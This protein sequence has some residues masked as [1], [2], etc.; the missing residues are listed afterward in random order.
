MKV[1]KKSLKIAGIILL[2]LILL[3]FIIPVVFKK[4]VQALV[5][6]EINKQLNAKVDF[7]DAKLSLFKHF[8][9][10]TIS[11]KGLTIVGKDYYA[12]DTLIS[13]N[14]IDITAG[15]FSVLKG[16]DI[17][18]YGVYVKQPRIHLLVNQ[19]GR[20]NW[21][22]AKAPADTSGAKD[23]TAS[24][25]KLSLKK[26]KIS[27]GYLEYNDKKA[28]TYTELTG[29][30][31][32]GSGDITADIFTLSTS[33]NAVSAKF[34][35]DGIPYLVNAKTDLDADIKIDNKTN[36]YTFKTDDIQLNALRLSAEGFVQMLNAE[37]FKMDFKFSSPANDFKNILSMVPAIYTKDFAK[38]KTSGEASFS[39][40]VKGIYSPTQI[41]AYDVKLLVKNGSF[42]YPD[43][44]KPVK[45]VNLSL[46][47]HNPD[48]KPDNSVIDISKGHLEFDKEPFDFNFIYRNP[49]TIQYIDAGAK[50]R[51]DL[52][53]LSK[54]IKLDA[55]TQLRGQVWADAF[56]KGP[57]KAIE[58][59]SGPFRAGGFFDIRNLYYADKNFPQP[60]QN[61]NMKA[62]LTNAGGVADKT[63]IDIAQGHIEVG[64]DP[65]DFTLQL[66]NPVSTVNFSGKAKG[67]FTLDNLKQF[68]S[69]LAGTSLS[70][71]M[72]ADMGFAGSRAAINNSEYDKITL[73]GS[74]DFANVS[75]KSKDYPGGISIPA[76][77]LLF[78]AKN[79]TL[80]NLTGKYLGT[81]FTAAG[82]LNNLVG[83]MMENQPLTGNLTAS[84]D[85]MN[86][87]DWMGTPAE[88][89]SAPS[90]ASASSGPFLVP[91]GVNFTINS[92]VNKVKY[93]KVDYD[94]ITGTVLMNDEKVQFQN[95]KAD[96]LD[97]SIL[98]NGSYSTK[99]NKEKPDISLSY[100]VKNMSVQKAFYA[101]NTIKFLMPIG[102]YLSGKLHSQLSM[103]G[104]LDGQMMPLLNSLTGKGN[105]F[106]LE[107]VLEKFAPL[108]KI[109]AVLD[110]D[111]LKS[112]SVKDI[113][114]YIEFANGKV[115]VKPF[116]V[117]VKDIEMEIAGFHGLDQ[118]LDYGIKMKM[119]RAVIGTK[120]NKLVDSLVAKAKAKGIPISPGETISLHL[121]LTGTVS[122]PSVS[123][124]LEKMAG[125]AVKQVEDLAKD[126]VKAKL[127]S[128]TKKTRDSLEAV[129]KQVEDK[130]K[131]KL[132]NAGIDTTN[133]TIKNVKDTLKERVK[134][135]LKKKI[136]KKLLGN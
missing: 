41:P 61:G 30:N 52:S 18:V 107:G 38:M 92:T 53:Q 91:P 130:A 103:I 76:S 55:G 8:P 90:A 122:N 118:S 2:S 97:G 121:K 102:K 120:G 106:L 109:A 33:T 128:A 39:G 13:A 74:A 116:T 136:I 59:Q 105:V 124:N 82:T 83:Y 101:F 70:G 94:N 5:K 51:L 26:Y 108:E 25:F 78:N 57:L 69:L 73:N 40:F 104:N 11:I 3:A 7:T 28:N 67:R 68:M 56:V 84:A 66:Q 1:L 85:N 117:K 75:Y 79:I 134:D 99:I 95:V 60:I 22:I 47:A 131:E 15:L 123:V 37:T 34:I 113:K 96:A 6:K 98:I 93:D 42:Q 23:T 72:N 119:P 31:H 62:T 127:D 80:N 112:I 29:L 10:A 43:L 88:E 19:F 14:K 4:Q 24:D 133:L 20:A 132:A 64:K 87:N 65:V 54:F 35:Q 27:N 125:D 81:N 36:T 129:K 12:K 44:P 21:D 89:S 63:V 126:F 46:H 32:N 115:F 17:K 58:Q 135:T 100:D 111:R 48:G 71:L 50:G 114:N 9:K 77:S 86:L 49:V 45:N 16:K 110:I